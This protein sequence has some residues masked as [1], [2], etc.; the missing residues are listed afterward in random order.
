M[1]NKEKTNWTEFWLDKLVIVAIFLIAGFFLNLRLERV[2]S[3]LSFYND[4]NK[5]RVEKVAEVWGKLDMY[6]AISEDHYQ[7]MQYPLTGTVQEREKQVEA[8]NK[9]TEAISLIYKDLRDTI[10]KNSFWLGEDA[11]NQ[12]IEYMKVTHEYFLTKIRFP[13]GPSIS[14]EK[15]KEAADKRAKHRQALEELRRSILSP[16]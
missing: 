5:M 2:K 4:I 7:R 15:N 14:E 12:I 1:A 9:E 10:E 8:W 11:H 13:P 16:P 3:D 6:H